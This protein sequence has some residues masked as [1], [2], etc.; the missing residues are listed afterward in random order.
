MKKEKPFFIF[1]IISTVFGA[2]GGVVAGLG[3]CPCVLAPVVSLM[4]VVILLFTFLVSNKVYF[5]MIGVS[6]LIISYLLHRKKT[7]HIHTKK[8]KRHK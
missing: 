2:L 5:V 7:C 6:L 1:G 4:G 8:L 3:L